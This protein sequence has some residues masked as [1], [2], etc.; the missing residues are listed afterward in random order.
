MYRYEGQKTFLWLYGG[1]TVYFTGYK[2]ENK[3]TVSRGGKTYLSHRRHCRRTRAKLHV[4][5]IISSRA[6]NFTSGWRPP[7]RLQC[8]LKV[9]NEQ[10][11]KQS[12][13]SSNGVITKTLFF[14]DDGIKF[15][16]KSCKGLVFGRHIYT[17]SAHMDNWPCLDA[18]EVGEGQTCACYK[19]K[20]AGHLFL[21]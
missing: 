10:C 5:M 6:G 1:V 12:V 21:G 19:L 20:K 15:S 9:P 3:V 14:A 11:R 4:I 17:R 7:R 18:R 2:S 8:L 13:H 16:T